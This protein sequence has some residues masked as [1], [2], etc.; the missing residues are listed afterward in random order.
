VKDW[1]IYSSQRNHID[2]FTNIRL[3][4]FYRYLYALQVFNKQWV[5]YKL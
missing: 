3:C 5:I 4:S 1:L 2:G